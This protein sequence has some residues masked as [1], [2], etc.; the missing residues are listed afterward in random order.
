LLEKKLE[1]E[2]G[3]LTLVEG[4][5][6]EMQE[7]YKSAMAGVG[8]GRAAGSAPNVDDIATGGGAQLKSELDN[9]DRSRRRAAHEADADERLAELKRRMG[10]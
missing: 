4:E 1:V 9:L 5:V 7:Q 8:S 6:T 2:Q 10:K 3:E